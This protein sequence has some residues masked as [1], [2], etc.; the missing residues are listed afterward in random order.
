MAL[1]ASFERI[2]FSVVQS[3]VPEQLQADVRAPTNWRLHTWLT[4][5]RAIDLFP[6]DPRVTTEMNL[7]IEVF[8]YFVIYFVN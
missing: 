1:R 3:R 5:D 4:E 2:N 6:L 8:S 7:A